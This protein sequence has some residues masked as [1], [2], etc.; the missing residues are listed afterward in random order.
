MV[1]KER[2]PR[3]YGENL[4]VMIHARFAPDLADKLARMAT[5]TGCSLSATLRRL[6]E[7]AQPAVNADGTWTMLAS[8]SRAGD[9]GCARR[10][11]RAR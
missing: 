8:E 5:S 3:P 10:G 9:G 1:T 11:R 7:Q 4:D 2:E 6:V